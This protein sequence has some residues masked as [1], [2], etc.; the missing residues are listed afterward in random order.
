MLASFARFARFQASDRAADQMR[1]RYPRLL[2]ILGLVEAGAAPAPFAWRARLQ[3][4]LRVAMRMR[5]PFPSLAHIRG[6]RW[7]RRG[8]GV[9]RME[10]TPSSDVSSWAM[11]VLH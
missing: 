3:V 10:R 6:P 8:I 2:H 7:S 9:F 5:Y 1:Q 11:R 4:S